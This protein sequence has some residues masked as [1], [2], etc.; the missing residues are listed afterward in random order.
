[1]LNSNKTYIQGL[2]IIALSGALVACGG[3]SS[4]TGSGSGLTEANQQTIAETTVEAADIND[5]VNSNIEA[6]TTLVGQASPNATQDLGCLNSGTRTLAFTDQNNDNTFNGTDTLVLTANNCDVGDV[7]LSGIITYTGNNTGSSNT[8][9]F[10]VE[11]TNF[12]SGGNSAN[13]SIDVQPS[14]DYDPST[15]TGSVAINIPSITF[16]EGGV[17]YTISNGDYL[18]TLG[19]N[20]TYTYASDFNYTSSQFS[21]T[22]SANTTTPFGG[23]TVGTNGFEIQNPDT[24]IMV[25]TLPDN[26]TATVDAGTGANSTYSLSINGSTVT[27]V[28]SN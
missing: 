5:L 15:N 24:G 23:S 4:S 8:P 25:I 27:K 26:S 2:S 11:L 18:L 6:L 16:V 3:G 10:K 13:G 1:M 21:G 12:V 22:V 17:S 9:G 14:T 28:W 7:V 20:N 19:Q